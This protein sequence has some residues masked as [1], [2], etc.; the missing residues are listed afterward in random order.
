MSKKEK[1]NGRLY[2]GVLVEDFHH[3]LDLVIEMMGHNE[4]ASRKRDENLERES[5]QF[6][7]SAFNML[8]KQISSVREDLGQ[9]IE[10]IGKH[11]D[12]HEGEITDLKK[13]VVHG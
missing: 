3:K 11:L 7:Q 6:V 13:A 4:E 5:K 2:N 9:K 12:R 8:S 10:L 1:N